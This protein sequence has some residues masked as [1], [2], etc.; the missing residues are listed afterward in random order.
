MS[1]QIT[2]RVSDRV[3]R[4]AAHVAAQSQRRIEDVLAD[5]FIG[6]ILTAQQISCT[7]CRSESHLALHPDDRRSGRF[8]VELPLRQR[9]MK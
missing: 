1:E 3:V 8:G 5:W 6:T 9:R 4:S 2:V 7:L